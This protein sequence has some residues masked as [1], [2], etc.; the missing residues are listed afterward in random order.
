MKRRAR[1][2]VRKFRKHVR[3]IVQNKK[4]IT[5][6]L[7]AVLAVFFI[8]S[9]KNIGLIRDALSPYQK[10][11]VPEEDSRLV[12]QGSGFSGTSG[13]AGYDWLYGSDNLYFEEV[14]DNVVLSD[15]SYYV[16]LDRKEK[17][18]WEANLYFSLG[19]E[20]APEMVTKEEVSRIGEACGYTDRETIS[21][22]H[23]AEEQG[24][25]EY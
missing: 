12:L 6:I 25:T 8:L 2:L 1:V 5:V 14:W 15:S 18:I 22:L 24:N 3:R 21:L 17:R 20:E 11:V 4:Q 19:W 7:L 9:I 10:K 23:E 16:T 13:K